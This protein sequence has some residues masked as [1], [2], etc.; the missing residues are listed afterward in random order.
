MSNLRPG[1]AGATRSCPHCK[2]TIL[3]SSSVC[4]ACK[5]H[6][7]F[8]SGTVQRESSTPL[9][10]DGTIRQPATGGPAEYSVLLSIRNERGE[11]ITRQVLGV[12]ALRPGDERTFSFTVE[13]SAAFDAKGAGKSSR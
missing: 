2:A 13:M 8:E 3:E 6:L 5:G 4:P 9:R 10:V 11:E 12:G 7:R 1:T